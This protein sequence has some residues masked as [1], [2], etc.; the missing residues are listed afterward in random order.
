[1]EIVTVETPSLGNRSYVVID[2]GV[3]AVIDP[4]RDID[5]IEA[6]I[7]EHGCRLAV[8][9]ETHRHADY[10]SGGLELARRHRATYAVPPGDPPCRFVHTPVVD[11]TVLSVG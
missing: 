6:V 2:A 5:R 4:P 8:V 10:V 7:T 1:M 3:G 9:A 11:M